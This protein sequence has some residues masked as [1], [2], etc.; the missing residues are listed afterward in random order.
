MQLTATSCYDFAESCYAPD[1]I[2][3]KTKAPAFG[4]S[5]FSIRFNLGRRLGQGRQQTRAVNR[6]NRG[7]KRNFRV[8]KLPIHNGD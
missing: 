5:P 3:K 7:L 8:A 1:A 6:Q 4:T 2:I